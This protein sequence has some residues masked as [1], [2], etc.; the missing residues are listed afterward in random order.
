MSQQPLPY[1]P[2]SRASILAYAERLVGHSLREAVN[3]LPGTLRLTSDKGSLGTDLERHY[4]GYEPN[5]RPEPDFADAGVELKATPLKTIRGKFVAKERLVLGMIDYMAV[6]SEEWESSTFLRKNSHLLLTFYLHEAGKDPRDFCF[7]IVRMW[8]FPPEDLAIIRQDWEKIIAKVRAGLAHELSEG[9]TLYLG[10]CTKSSD[11]TKRRAQPHSDEPAKPRAFSLKASYMNSIINDSLAMKP[12]AAAEVARGISFEDAIAARFEPY[13]G[14]T[15]DAIAQ[16]LD[17]GTTSRAKGFY[18][19]LTKRILGLGKKDRVAEF[20]KADIQVKTM[21]LKPSGTPKE[22]ISFPAFNYLDLVVQDWDSS[23]LRSV[24]SKRFFFVIYQLDR[25]NVPILVGTRFW[26]MPVSD[27][28]TRARE[29]F[30]ETVLRIQEDRAEYLPKKSENPAVHV[31]PHGRNSKDVIPVPSGRL[32]CRKS[33][34]L[35]GSYIK[36]QLGL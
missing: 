12:V 33:F 14:M 20:E 31:R 28:D 32:V 36:H 25:N 17:V 3:E 34:W 30:D 8:D 29:C 27:I 1:D 7:K 5:S 15:A 23:D 22:D 24:L 4:F 26:T 10:A 21:R 16:R 18:A 19:L 2:T 35:N 13:I 9:D 6:I 11:S